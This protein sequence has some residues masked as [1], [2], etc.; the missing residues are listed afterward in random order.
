[1]SVRIS[2]VGHGCPFIGY[3]QAGNN[4][5]VF[6]YSSVYSWNKE[7]ITE[8]STSAVVVNVGFS[9]L[10]Y[11]FGRMVSGCLGEDMR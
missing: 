6:V 10:W 8:E 11:E 7:K 1:M 4:I 5:F 9:V 2:S 3:T